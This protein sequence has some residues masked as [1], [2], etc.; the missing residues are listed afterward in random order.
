VR[1][2]ARSVWTTCRIRAVTAI[3]QART[4]R[5]ATAIRPATAI[6]LAKPIRP[7]TPGP[8]SPV[9]RPV[10]LTVAA[11]VAAVIAGT[12][13]TIAT[14]SHPA[15]Q[16]GPAVSAAGRAAARQ[17]PARPGPAGLT[18]LLVPDGSPV[19][20]A[21]LTAA[22]ASAAVP[23]VQT[24]AIGPGAK[25]PGAGAATVGLAVAPLGQLRP[26][27]LLVVSPVTLPAALTA[28]LARLPGVTATDA[29]DA[30]AIKVDGQFVQMLGVSPGQFRAFA[31]A[32]TAKS[33]SLWRSVAAGGVAVSYTMGKLDKLPLGG[34]VTVAGR[35]TEKLRVGAFGTVGIS[36]VDAV[37][38]D[39]VAQSL[40]I[41][42]GNA[43]VISAPKVSLAALAAQVQGLLPR[44]AG[45]AQLVTQAQPGVPGAAALAA[46]GAAGSTAAGAG[47]QAP[48]T[49]AQVSA[50]LRA[51]LSRVGLPYVWG[52]AGPAAFDCS[53]L[54]QWSMAQAGLVMPRV[55]ADQARTGPL[56]SLGE[57]RPGDLLFYHTDVTAPTYISHVA[58]YLGDNQ[59]EQAPEP[60]MDVQVVPADFGPAFAGAVQVAPAVAAAVA[61]DPAG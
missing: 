42:A 2:G 13:G 15:G 23:A 3:R 24:S 18:G 50:F 28:R 44:G 5:S 45:L 14:A 38:S 33:D 8:L 16:P 22:G 48:M 43:L 26:A 40:G 53:G 9:T 20:G 35:Q 27:D 55:A 49:S 19:S 29:L 51:A 47:G 52:A 37:V 61:G 30:A 31:A 60:G 17:S 36:G 1:N 58:I 56:I 59:M 46:A 21:Q 12:G 7:V 11:L 32:P 4:A 54:V 34:T 10:V 39:Q 41:P 25:A 6:R 57:L